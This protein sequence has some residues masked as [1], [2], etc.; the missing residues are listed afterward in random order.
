MNTSGNHS[1]VIKQMPDLHPVLKIPKD[2]MDKDLDLIGVPGGHINLRTGQLCP[3]DRS[4]YITKQLAVAPDGTCDTD[5]FDA[6]LKQVIPDK[7]VREWLWH[8][9]G[10]LLTGEVSAQIFTVFVGT[11]RNGKGVLTELLSWMLGGYAGALNTQV[12]MMKDNV[13]KSPELAGLRGFRFISAE[14]ASGTRTW[15]DAL[16]KLMTGESH[17]TARK[18]Y[19]NEISYMPQFKLTVNT[20]ELPRI[21]NTGPAMRERMKVVRFPVYISED[22]RDPNLGKRLRTEAPGILYK[23]AQY[24]SK[25]LMDG[26]PAVPEAMAKE[27][28]DYFEDNDTI[29]QW[30]NDR[31]REQDGATLRSTAAYLDYKSWLTDGLYL[32]PATAFGQRFASLAHK[33]PSKR[34]RQGKE[35]GGIRIKKGAIL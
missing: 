13:N 12:L 33:Y 34:V 32:H 3:P 15:D 10:Y 22:Q 17:V 23:M 5:R 7:E 11:G 8:W 19:Q 30:Y 29:L 6:F 18:L 25:V 16:I 9:F 2:A 35:Y 1:G 21:R 28:R 14:E 26:M 27:N 4:I 20:N 31:I 24:A